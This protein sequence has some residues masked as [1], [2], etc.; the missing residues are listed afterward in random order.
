MASDFIPDLSPEL[1]PGG[2]RSTI[3]GK[4]RGPAAGRPRGPGGHGAA[5]KKA[6]RI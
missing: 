4:A 3:P 5:G 6:A 2:Y 1:K